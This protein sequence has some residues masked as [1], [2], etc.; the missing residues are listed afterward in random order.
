[1]TANRWNAKL[2]FSLLFLDTKIH[3]Q[4]QK[5]HYYRK[6][7]TSKLYFFRRHPLTS[8]LTSTRRIRDSAFQ[9]SRTPG[10]AHAPLSRHATDG[11]WLEL[12]GW[13]RRDGLVGFRVS[14]R[15][16]WLELA[17]DIVQLF[18]GVNL[19]VGEVV[20]DLGDLKRKTAMTRTANKLELTYGQDGQDRQTVSCRTKWMSTACNFY[21]VFW[22]T[23]ISL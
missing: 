5:P 18:L 11:V 21:E 16:A 2:T 7:F 13:A 3:V 17:R 8:G 22:N 14:P 10:Q 1:M 15:E 23:K 19:F 6:I 12:G 20:S 4:F 9:G